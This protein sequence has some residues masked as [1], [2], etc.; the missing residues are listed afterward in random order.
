MACIEIDGWASKQTAP[1][2]AL[3]KALRNGLNVGA[4]LETFVI[5]CI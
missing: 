3:Q 5:V 1:S 4:A 2:N